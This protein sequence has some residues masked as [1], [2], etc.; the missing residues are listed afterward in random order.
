[1]KNKNIY[2]RITQYQKHLIKDLLE[3]NGIS[4]S[5]DETITPSDLILF[6]Y[7]NSKI[8]EV[9]LNNFSDAE[10]RVTPEAF[11]DIEKMV[12]GDIKDFCGIISDKVYLSMAETNIILHKNG[13]ILMAMPFSY[14][15]I[16]KENI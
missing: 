14:T 11:I 16:Y 13:K 12:N 3:E 6:Q 7:N 2:V 15:P 9:K 10:I 4:V 1:M 8:Q 5:F